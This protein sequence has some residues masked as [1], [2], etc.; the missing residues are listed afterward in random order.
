[1]RFSRIQL[2][3][4]RNFAQVNIAL[5]N[6][7][8]IVG[9]NASGKSNLLDVFRF[10]RDLVATG[11][12]FQEAVLRRG[13]VS[14]IRNL[15]ARNN[16]NVAIVATLLDDDDSEWRYRL[17]FNQD[18]RS[19][20]VLRE[21][22]VV[23][24]V[25]GN[26]L[27]MLHRP[28]LDDREDEARL[29]Q[30]HLEQTFANKDFRPIVDFLKSI[31]YSHVVP[32]LIRDPERSIG[33]QDDPFG[34]DFIE[35][36]ASV[37]PKTRDARLARIQSALRIAVPQLDQLEL[38]RDARTGEAHLRA[39]YQHWRPQG[40]WQNETDLS[41]GTLRLIGLLWTLQTGSGPLLLEE[42]ELS[43]HPAVVRS[44]PQMM[45]RVQRERKSGPR[46]TFVTTHSSELLNGKGISPIEVLLLRPASEGTTVRDINDIYE[47]RVE[48]E[49]GLTIGE[50]VQP[51]TK[52]QNADQLVL[53]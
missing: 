20:P 10:L 41:D 38:L 37:T 21:E 22:S 32:Q 46:Q 42:P 33:R 24:S 39:N 30:T 12:G 31:S 44:I 25:N 19:R 52:P 49:A 45:Y 27:L 28:D 36:I 8:F 7:V 9:P 16:T 26:D 51:L 5:Q 15:A 29:S 18:N 1:M 4:W 53:L 35:Q 17:V 40:A 3:N 48:L 43:L 2:E 23:R 47:V 50:V 6:R 13:G 14:K 11:G 34:G